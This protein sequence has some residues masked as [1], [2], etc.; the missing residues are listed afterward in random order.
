MRDLSSGT[1]N[2]SIMC[3]AKIHQNLSLSAHNLISTM[4][5]GECCLINQV[6][7]RL[8][9]SANRCFISRSKK[10]DHCLCSIALTCPLDSMVTNKLNCKLLNA[11]VFHVI[12]IQFLDVFF[13]VFYLSIRAVMGTFFIQISSE[14]KLGLFE[15]TFVSQSVSQLAT[16]LLVICFGN[17]LPIKYY[18]RDWNI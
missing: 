10:T 15:L 9:V 7:N 13:L 4:I 2:L 17:M 12:V 14:T 16:H 5:D 3:A 11:F 1:L 18:P 6:E 8:K